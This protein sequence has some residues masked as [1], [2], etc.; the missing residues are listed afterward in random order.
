[1]SYGTSQPSSKLI[2]FGNLLK[3]GARSTRDAKHT[4]DVSKRIFKK[5]I[6]IHG[7]QGTVYNDMRF[8][9][10]GW[11]FSKRTLEVKSC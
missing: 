8:R 5:K 7:Y 10:I 1:M 9:S 3:V 2:Q 11:R 6:P 4:T